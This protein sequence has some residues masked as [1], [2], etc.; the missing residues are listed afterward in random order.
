MRPLL[1]SATAVPCLLARLMVESPLQSWRSHGAGIPSSATIWRPFA[2]P[3][4]QLIPF[5]K[6]AGLRDGP[7]ARAIEA[8]ACPFRH[9]PATGLDGVPRKL[10]RVGDMFPSSGSGVL[11][12][13]FAFVL[14]GFATQASVTRYRPDLRDVDR[15]KSTVSENAPGWGVSPG[16][17]LLKFLKVVDILSQA[18]CYLLKLGP[19]E[20]SAALIEQAMGATCS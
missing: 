1:E 15:L 11:P 5:P 14:D 7:F 9:V 2:F 19:P 8:Q 4:R 6:S 12:L 13:Q 10:V 16:R 18:R 20:D 17:D 3:D